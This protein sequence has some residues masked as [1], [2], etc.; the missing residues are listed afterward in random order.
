MSRLPTQMPFSLQ[1]LEVASHPFLKSKKF[2]KLAL[3]K[4][5]DFLPPLFSLFPLSFLSSSSSSHIIAKNES[6]FLSPY[7]Q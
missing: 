4:M 6:M 1:V 5:W 3:E 2:S 7:V